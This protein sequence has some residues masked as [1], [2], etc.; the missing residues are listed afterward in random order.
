MPARELLFSS[1]LF[2]G[3]TVSD[4]RD[5]LRMFLDTI[6]E[7]GVLTSDELV[8]IVIGFKD[9]RFSLAQIEGMHKGLKRLNLF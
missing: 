2:A 7:F 5:L 4:S 3:L 8:G 6:D 9:S 1:S